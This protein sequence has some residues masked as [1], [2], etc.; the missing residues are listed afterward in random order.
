[1]RDQ[2][3]KLVTTTTQMPATETCACDICNKLIFRRSIID[4]ED[5][6]K[7]TRQVAYWGVTTGHNDWGYDSVD[8]IFNYDI[9]SIECLQ[10]LFDKYSEESCE[11][12]TKR[13]TCYMDIK[14][15]YTGAYEV[16]D[17]TFAIM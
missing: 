12:N 10:K 7:N 2:D 15:N 11:R 13:N 6:P 1:V 9:C 3:I 17:E 5:V 14:H 8:S 16:G 4:S